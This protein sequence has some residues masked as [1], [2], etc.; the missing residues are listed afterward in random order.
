MI[1]NICCS[2]NSCGTQ[3]LTISIEYCSIRTK[4]LLSES[5]SIF[6]TYG[7]TPTMQ[8]AKSTKSFINF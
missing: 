3:T 4:L 6:V 2:M 7:S 8:K 1:E 5:E